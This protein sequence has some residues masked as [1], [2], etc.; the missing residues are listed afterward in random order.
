MP[1]TNAAAAVVAQ[2]AVAPTMAASAFPIVAQTAPMV[3]Q[4]PA[5]VYQQPEKQIKYW[6]ALLVGPT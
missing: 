5:P 1:A 4:A 6:Y 2:P 3:T